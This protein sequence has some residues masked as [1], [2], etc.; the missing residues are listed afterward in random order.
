MGNEVSAA[1]YTAHFSAPPALPWPIVLSLEI[2]PYGIEPPEELLSLIREEYEETLKFFAE[3]DIDMGRLGKRAHSWT[4]RQCVIVFTLEICHGGYGESYYVY[5]SMWI[6]D[7]TMSEDTIPSLPSVGS[8]D[9]SPALSEAS[10]LSACTID[11]FYDS[12]CSFD[13]THD[14]Y[15]GPGSQITLLPSASPASP[16]NH[17]HIVSIPCPSI[18]LQSSTSSLSLGQEVLSESLGPGSENP[19]SDTSI[20]RSEANAVMGSCDAEGPSSFSHFLYPLTRR[21]K[22]KKLVHEGCKGKFCEGGKLFTRSLSR[23]LKV[24]RSRTLSA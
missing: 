17:G 10:P 3:L 16:P 15:E 19:G 23:I 4:E 24:V 8:S 11:S 2:N 18:S 1:L 6:F 7:P 21:L 20:P 12:S 13:L 22:K 9:K 14:C 5:D